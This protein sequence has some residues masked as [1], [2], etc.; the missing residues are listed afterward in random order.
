MDRW[1]SR[2]SLTKLL[3]YSMLCTIAL[4]GFCYAFTWK[5]L[6]VDTLNVPGSGYE[7]LIPAGTTLTKFTEQLHTDG[8]LHYPRLMRVYLI[9]KGNTQQ[10]K[11]GEYKIEPGTTALQL[12]D[13]VFQGAVVQYSFTIVEGWQTK[14]LLEQLQQHPK[15]K[16][17]LQGLSDKQIIKALALPVNH[18]EGIFLPDTY[19][20]EAETTDVEFLRRAYFSMQA[21]L[22]LAW[23]Q[24]DANTILKDPYE[25]LILASI[26]EK[27]TNL[28]SEYKQIA[29][30]FTRRLNKNMKLQ[31]DPTVIYGLQSKL[32]GP[33]LRK[34]LK[35]DSPY[36]S[37]MRHGLPPTP[38]ALPS[39]SAIEAVLHPATGNDLYFVATGEQDG[40]HIFSATLQ[41]HNTAVQQLYKTRRK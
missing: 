14:Q 6:A 7:L 39:M 13:K 30:V 33:L 25:V 3:R 15:I 36:N 29:G 8:V 21:K 35:H 28:K 38:I 31:A 20:F 26:I 5:A 9:Y 34:H 11:A 10:I 19:C 37:Y 4:I 18:L 16:T 40:G 41:E 1:P 22:Q 32:D 12:L 24:R 2:S 17:T 27:E 23:E